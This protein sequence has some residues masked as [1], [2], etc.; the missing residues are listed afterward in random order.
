MNLQQTIAHR[1]AY[2][3][4]F[5]CSAMLFT[6]AALLPGIGPAVYA[7]EVRPGDIVIIIT[8]GTEARLCPDP[9]CGPDKHI[10]RIPEGTGLTV[11]DIEAFVI[12]TFKVQWLA[13]EYR[14]QRGWISIYDTNRAKK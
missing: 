14:N 3:F 7:D 6:L 12:G 4:A 11:H 2:R 1:P 10:T 5:I 8:P 9:G 13:V